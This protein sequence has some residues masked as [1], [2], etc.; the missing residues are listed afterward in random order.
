M[1]VLVTGDPPGREGLDL[2]DRLS[3]RPDAANEHTFPEVH[4]SAVVDHIAGDNQY[5]CPDVS[6][7]GE[8]NV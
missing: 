6:A 8:C 2:V 5:W 7:T 4:V 3:P 1:F